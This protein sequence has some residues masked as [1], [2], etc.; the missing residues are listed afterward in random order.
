MNEKSAPNTKV[1]SVNTGRHSAVAIARE[2]LY[3]HCNIQAKKAMDRGF[4]LEAIA[5][6]ESMITDRLESRI[7]AIHGQDET[8][9]TFRT[10]GYL[11]H[12]RGSKAC[13]IQRLSGLLDK[14]LA[15]PEDLLVVY[16]RV[17]EWSAGRNTC[18][19]QMVKLGG[20]ASKNWAERIAYAK[21]TAESGLKIFRELSSLIDKHRNSLP[22]YP[23]SSGSL[24][25]TCSATSGPASP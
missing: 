15:E 24:P 12:G 6:L 3:S 21:E 5:L 23:L 7:A 25:N 9:R 13:K 10:I 2:D 16:R 19:H 20:K 11:L 22:S 1:R 14:E 8:C 17:E 4:Y 18:L